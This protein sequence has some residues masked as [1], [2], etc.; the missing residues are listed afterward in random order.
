LHKLAGSSKT[1]TFSSHEYA[2]PNAL[3]YICHSN[4][5]ENL[6]SQ[7][8]ISIPQEMQKIYEPLRNTY[9]IRLVELLPGNK[10]DPIEIMLWIFS[11][12][13]A[14]SYEAISYVWGTEQA[15]VEMFCNGTSQKIGRNLADAL[16]N[17][18]DGEKVR[19]LFGS[20]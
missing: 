11:L 17:F 15:C 18:R 20:T 10:H 5:S 9:S 2:R 16:L 7:K 1:T 19:V 13:K 8:P 4:T 3:V 12:K 6:L 14:P